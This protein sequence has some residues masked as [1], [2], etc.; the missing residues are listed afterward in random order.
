MGSIRRT[1]HMVVTLLESTAQELV[2]R[3]RIKLNP[4]CLL[5]TSLIT[6][7]TIASN[8]PYICDWS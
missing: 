8:L 1:I 6:S 7:A 2:L 5:T 4:G 3:T